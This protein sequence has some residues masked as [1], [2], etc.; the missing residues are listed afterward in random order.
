MTPIIHAHQLSKVFT[1]PNGGPIE[2]LGPLDLTVTAGEF[3]CIV[4]PSGCGKSTLLRLLAELDAPTAG[5]LHLA[6]DSRSARAQPAGERQQPLNSMVFQGDSTFPWYTVYENVAYGLRVRGVGT[7][8]R[9]ATVRRM[10]QTVGLTQF[11]EAY[12]YQL[13]GGMRQRVALARALANDPVMLLMDE[14]FGALDAQNRVI[15][16]EELLRLWDD[17][18]KT[19]IFVTHSIEE[20]LVLAD[21]VLVMSARPGRIKEEIVVPFSRPRQAY[22]LRRDSQFGE[23]SYHVWELLRSEVEQGRAQLEAIA[24]APRG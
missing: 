1:G 23:L 10:L 21:R 24:Q 7:R 16:Q 6:A 3:V 4:G 11:A 9:D 12:P 5:E 8:Q 19:V 22:E 20:A 18:D 13:S 2:A 15:L 17:T 14:P